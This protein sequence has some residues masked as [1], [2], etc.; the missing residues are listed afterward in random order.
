MRHTQ[1]GR[2]SFF[3]AAGNDRRRGVV[4]LQATNERNTGVR[5][6]KKNVGHRFKKHQGREGE[7]C[8]LYPVVRYLVFMESTKLTDSWKGNASFLSYLFST[9]SFFTLLR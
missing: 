2:T 3:F 5:G 6:R 7:S 1:Q 8:T 9:R 4:L